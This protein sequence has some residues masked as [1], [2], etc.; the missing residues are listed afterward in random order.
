[1][2][3]PSTITKVRPFA[4]GPAQHR[5]ERGG[6]AGEQA[7]GLAETAGVSIPTVLT[8]R[9]RYQKSGISGLGDAPHPG[10][11]RTTDDCDRGT[12]SATQAAG[13]HAL[14]LQVAGREA[15][16]LSGYG[17]TCLAGLWDPAPA[18]RVVPLLHRS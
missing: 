1:M 14:V 2:R 10:R 4:A 16:E 17:G 7:H 3:V 8:W 9:G 6:K 15:K 5:R 11:P 18:R 13:G 12:D